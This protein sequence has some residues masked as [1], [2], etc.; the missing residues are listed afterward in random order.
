MLAIDRRKQIMNYLTE[1]ETATRQELAEALAVTPMTIGRDFKKLE[2]EG[3]LETTHGGAMLPMDLA[4][5]FLY[6]SKKHENKEV[7]TKIAIQAMS[8]IHDGMTIVLDA[9]T[10]TFEIAD[11]IKKSHFKHLTVITCDLYIGLHLYQC[12]G[13][14]VILLGGEVLKKTGA[15]A[16]E[17][18]VKQLEMYNADITFTGIS[19]VTQDYA[20]SVPLESKVFLKRML[21]HSSKVSVLVVDKSKFGKK[22]L[23]RA[24]NLSDFTY[25]ITD[26]KFTDDEMAKY[27]LRD[28]IININ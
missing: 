27:K 25:V 3:L 28:K 6:K 17:I 14:R 18:S 26:Y 12:E 8:L 23:F 10:T 19:S 21:I 11:A 7:K 2:K 24:A 5:E 20:L 1:N 13:I 22:K 16:S 15:V 9:G 4:E